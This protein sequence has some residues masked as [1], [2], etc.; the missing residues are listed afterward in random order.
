VWQSWDP[1]ITQTSAEL[2]RTRKATATTQISRRTDS[3][4]VLTLADWQPTTHITIVPSG[5][6]SHAKL[7]I[8]PLFCKNIDICNTAV[9]DGTVGRSSRQI[10]PTHNEYVSLTVALTTKLA[11]SVQSNKYKK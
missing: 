11:V 9:S 2:R 1:D 6:A 5:Q 10:G 8:P 3:T 4:V 7:L